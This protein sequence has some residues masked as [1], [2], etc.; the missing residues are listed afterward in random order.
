MRGLGT[1]ACETPDK[2]GRAGGTRPALVAWSPQGWGSTLC[3][4]SPWPGVRISPFPWARSPG[5]VQLGPL[6]RGPQGCH[7]GVGQTAFLSEAQGHLPSFGSCWKNSVL[8]GCRTNVP[9]FLPTGHGLPEAA[10]T[11][12][13][14]FSSSSS[15]G[16]CLPLLSAMGSKGTMGTTSITTVTFERSEAL[17]VTGSFH[18]RGQ[19]TAQM[20]MWLRWG[21]LRVIIAQYHQPWDTEPQARLTHSWTSPSGEFNFPKN[22]CLVE[23][24]NF[25]KNL[26]V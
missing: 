16:E 26:F 23:E 11:Q 21:Q 4:G 7:Q 12:H 9:P 15:A 14:S 8:S 22:L 24:F 13:G 1:M 19:E 5:T 18:P 25:S 2:V 3:K 6:P 10:L 17:K 20:L